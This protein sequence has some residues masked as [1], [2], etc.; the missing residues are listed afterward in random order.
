M[1]IE[2]ATIGFEDAERATVASIGGE[3]DM[4]NAD[5]LL[6]ELAQRHRLQPRAGVAESIEFMQDLFDPGKIVRD[7]GELVAQP[8]LA[9]QDVLNRQRDIVFQFLDALGIRRL[10]L[11]FVQCLVELAGWRHGD[12]LAQPAQAHIDRHQLVAQIVQHAGRHLR[13]S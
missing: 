1:P 10:T 11:Q 9:T 7:V 12:E 5:R 2:L 6:D 8:A 3:V 13:Q 4:S